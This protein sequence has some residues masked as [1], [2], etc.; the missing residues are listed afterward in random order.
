MNLIIPAKCF[1]KKPT[2]NPFR[3]HYYAEDV[4]GEFVLDQFSTEEL[5]A[6]LRK[7]RLKEI[8]PF[9]TAFSLELSN[10]RTNDEK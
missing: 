8:R 9:T 3:N 10:Q 2:E 5:E 1:T 7:L 6:Q 4:N